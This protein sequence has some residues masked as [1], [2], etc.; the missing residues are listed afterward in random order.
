MASLSGAAAVRLIREPVKGL[1]TF[2]DRAVA[3]VMRYSGGKPYAIQRLCSAVVRQ[4]LAEERSQ[5]TAE[6]VQQAHRALV[7]E[8]QRRAAQG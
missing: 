4:A 8:D 6:D 5:I 1:F 2:D 7:A 3:H